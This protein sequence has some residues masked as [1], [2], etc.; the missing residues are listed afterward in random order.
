M[1][2]LLFLTWLAIR[3]GTRLLDLLSRRGP[4]MR[5][6]AK[7]A[8]PVLRVVLWFAAMFVSV[9]LLA[10]TRETF[11]AAIGSAAIAI[12]LGAQ[13]LIRN[14]I[15]GLVILGDRPYQ[16]GD[17]VQIGDA[18]GEIDH[19]GLRS[20]KLTTFGDTRVTIPNAEI[21]NNQVFD[22]NSGVPYCQ[23]EAILHLPTDTDPDEAL[24]IGFEAAYTC[25]YLYSAKPVVVL[26]EDKFNLNP[27]LEMHIKAYVCDH[28]LVPRMQSDII[29]RAKREFLRRGLLKNWP[30]LP[31]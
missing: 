26:I 18:Y 13:D 23:L 27:Y 1:V 11:L 9:E 15:G 10:P 20:T 31:A 5:F 7:G 22:S 2:A 14:L 19:I 21:L 6:L 16:L 29:V 24:R 4:R 8:E 12:G 3:W 25:P 28:R 30:L 17:L